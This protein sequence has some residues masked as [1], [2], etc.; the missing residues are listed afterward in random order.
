VNHTDERAEEVTS[1]RIHCI[2]LEQRYIASMLS[3]ILGNRVTAKTQG[4]SELEGI[5]IQIYEIV[6]IQAR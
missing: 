6:F 1:L 2:N 4:I 5:Y 3:T